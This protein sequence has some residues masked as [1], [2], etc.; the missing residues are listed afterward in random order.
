MVELAPHHKIGLTLAHPLMLGSGFAGYG[1]L[2]RDLIDLNAFAAVV[3]NPITLRPQYAPPSPRLAETTGGFILNIGLTN[4]GVK[5][6]I[7]QYHKIWA[8]LTTP[9]IAHLPAADPHDLARTAQ[10]LAGLTTPQ[11]DPLI[12]AFELGVPLDST[13]AELMAW[14]QALQSDDICPILVKLPLGGS[15]DL[16]EA[17]TQA[18]A[19]ALVIGAPPLGTGMTA[20]GE[21]ITGPVYGA[22]LPN[23]VLYDLQLIRDL[24]PLPLIAVGGIHRLSDIDMF[25]A[26]GATAVQLDS[27][28][29]VEPEQVRELL[30]A[31]QRKTN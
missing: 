31:V 8:R 27:L 12:A 24:T 1:Q 11:G 20:A 17:A 4:P 23:L 6:I 7:Q 25:L 18:H 15:W 5:R 2:Y 13:P 30:V 9:V 10:A 19:D 16:V 14:L 22:A 26:A 29:W 21:F 28:M 3:T